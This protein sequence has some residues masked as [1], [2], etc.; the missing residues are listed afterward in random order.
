[1]NELM[2]AIESMENAMIKKGDMIVVL[3]YEVAKKYLEETNNILQTPIK[4][5]KTVYGVDVEVV[6]FLPLNSEFYIFTKKYWES[7]QKF[8]E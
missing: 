2:K 7:V 4:Q 8:Y 3:S 5:F 6:N 1:M